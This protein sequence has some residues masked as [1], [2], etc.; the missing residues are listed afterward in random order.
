[1]NTIAHINND[2]NPK[3]T[4]WLVIGDPRC[5][6]DRS[7]CVGNVNG[8]NQLIVLKVSLMPSTGH[9]IPHKV[10]IGMKRLNVR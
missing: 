9:I 2:K 3:Y 1:M 10:R 5:K 7:P 6:I 4:N 8:Q